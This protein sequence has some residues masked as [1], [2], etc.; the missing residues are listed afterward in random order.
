M[1]GILSAVVI[2]MAWQTLQAVFLI[3]MDTSQPW[4][5][6]PD[7]DIIAVLL[8]PARLLGLVNKRLAM[9]RVPCEEYFQL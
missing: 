6:A 2:F 4:P 8:R 7:V 5:E 9:L 3:Q 1:W